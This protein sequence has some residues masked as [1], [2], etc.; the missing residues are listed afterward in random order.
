MYKNIL[1]TIIIAIFAGCG[2]P[3]TPQKPAWYTS[4]PKDFTKF[5]A[6]GS[7]FDESKAKN[8]A[9]LALRDR[10]H[11]DLDNAFKKEDHQ[12]SLTKEN[13]LSNI[14]KFNERRANTLSLRRL[15]VEKTAEFD[16]K[17]LVLV[18]ILKKDLFESLSEVSDKK[19]QASQDRHLKVQSAV[20]IQRFATTKEI[21]LEYDNLAS[22]IQFKQIILSTY[23]PSDEFEYLNR[24]DSDYKKLKEDVSVY[25]L[26]D[27]NSI[28]FYK[29]IK[30]AILATGL[31]IS[32]KPKS[33]DSI[34][35]LISS[36]TTNEDEYTFKKARTL[37]KFTTYNT[38]REKIKFKQHTFSGKSTK[39]YRE[40]KFQ[41]ALY[42]K[43]KLQKE[44]IFQFIGVLK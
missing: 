44:G 11:I 4:P 41:S 8:V 36:K 9:S 29:S 10:L 22:D 5:Y 20:A 12:L 6:V 19:F 17:T 38:S 21:L 2:Q 16:G 24:L 13:R 23:N 42:L 18:S 39:T 40:A 14:L 37:V 31:T 25:I 1:L 32:K 3:D 27:G 7:A 26:T 43:A 34:K 28:P 35:L 33:A 15:K 30:E